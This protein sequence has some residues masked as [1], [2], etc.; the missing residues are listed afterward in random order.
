M[1]EAAAKAG[2]D[3]AVIDTPPHTVDTALVAA[4]EADL[5]LIPCHPATA[6]LHAIETTIR[7]ARLAQ[8]PAA[9]VLNGALV[10]HRV[11]EEALEAI[12]QYEVVACPVILHQRID[13]QHSFTRGMTAPEFA[14]RGAAAEEMQALERWIHDVQKNGG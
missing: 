6:D 7:V 12:R 1:L 13:H 11:N 3:L 8:K 5:I 2:S 9:V 14:P 4:R 10:H